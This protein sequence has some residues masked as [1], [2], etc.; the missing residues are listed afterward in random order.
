MNGNYNKV[1]SRSEIFFGPP[2]KDRAA[3][4]VYIK[5]ERLTISYRAIWAW[6]ERVNMNNQQIMILPRKTIKC[7]I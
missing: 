7:T 3:K 5:S 2:S 1:G 4:K 6:S